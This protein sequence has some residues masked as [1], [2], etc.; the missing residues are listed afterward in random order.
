[1]NLLLLV[2]RIYGFHLTKSL[3]N[4]PSNVPVRHDRKIAGE[5]DI[6]T[7]DPGRVHLVQAAQTVDRN[8]LAKL[9][10][11]DFRRHRF[12]AHATR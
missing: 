11:R 12:A 5:D 10:A 7:I 1:M 9:D 8:V 2:L 6:I 4:Y 3:K